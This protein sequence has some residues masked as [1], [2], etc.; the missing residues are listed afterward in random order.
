MDNI[1]FTARARYSNGSWSENSGFG[2][3]SFTSEAAADAWAAEQLRNDPGA[4]VIVWKFSFLPILLGGNHP[5]LPDIA[6]L[7]LPDGEHS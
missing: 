7:W 2:C 3:R 5:A 4:L 6:Y 1:K